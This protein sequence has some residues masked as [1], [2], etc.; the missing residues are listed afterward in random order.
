ML[1]ESSCE[2]RLGL[3]C[4]SF[5]VCTRVDPG[6]LGRGLG[7]YIRAGPLELLYRQ[8]PGMNSTLT[9]ITALL[10]WS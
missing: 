7:P 10:P 8:R 3:G 4:C 9:L 6:L 1:E 5:Y 2:V